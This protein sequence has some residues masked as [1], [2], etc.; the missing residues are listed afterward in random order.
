M[1]G[2]YTMVAETFPAQMRATG[3]GFVMG[4]GRIGAALSPAIAGALFGL[5]GGRGEVSAMM[6]LGALLAGLIVA[7][8]PTPQQVG[9]PIKT[10]V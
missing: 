1:A 6:G 4:I 2:L 10:P 7:F 9:V 3:A 8:S 5:G